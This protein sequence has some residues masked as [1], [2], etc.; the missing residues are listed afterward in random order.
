MNTSPYWNRFLLAKYA[1]RPKAAEGHERL[2]DSIEITILGLLTVQSLK[3]R[4]ETE[5]NT[6]DPAVFWEILIHKHTD[7]RTTIRGR[8]LKDL[9]FLPTD[10]SQVFKK[11]L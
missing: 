7:W 8:L 3:S 1:V 2:L 5:R 11:K 6:R 4:A 10:S 9:F